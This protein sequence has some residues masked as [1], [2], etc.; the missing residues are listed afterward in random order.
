[1]EHREYIRICDH[2][3]I[4][5]LFIHGIIGTPN[6]FNE[7]IPLV[8]ESISVYNLLLDG[9][10]KGVKDFS[11]TSMEKW[12]SQVA[13]AVEDLA[14]THESIY[15]VAHSLGALL[16]IGQAVNNQKICNLFLLQVPLRLWLKPKMFGNVCKVYFD[17]ISPDDLE[18]LA[19]KNSFGI[20]LD[21]NPFPYMGWIPRYLELLAKIRQTRKI[22]K[23]VNVNCMVYQSRND[24]MVSWKSR[25]YLSQNPS[26]SVKELKN[27]AHYY[28]AREDWAFLLEEFKTMLNIN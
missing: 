26:I 6:H 8:P 15:I 28:Y 20:H 25:E 10:G 5:V 21:K 4:A 27:S 1:M 19:A 16:A 3:D 24:E 12:E 7:F 14:L 9:H 18:A 17:K 13:S 2:S 23:Q 11:K 22:L